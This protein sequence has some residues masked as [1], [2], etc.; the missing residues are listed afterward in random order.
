MPMG[1]IVFKVDDQLDRQ[2]RAAA[3]AGRRTVSEE[4]GL[5]LRHSLA[6]VPKV[7]VV[8]ETADNQEI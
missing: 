3:K 6:A 8:F 5:R 1:Q 7:K 4:A 2:I